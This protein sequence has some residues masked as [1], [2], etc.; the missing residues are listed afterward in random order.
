MTD[1]IKN[2]ESKRNSL[3]EKLTNLEAL[4]RGTISINYQKCGKKNCACAKPDRKIE[5]KSW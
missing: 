1:T 4:R 5:A 3:H 2:L